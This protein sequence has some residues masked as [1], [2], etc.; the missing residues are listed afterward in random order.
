MK[1]D[2]AA[3]AAYTTTDAATV[4]D[5]VRRFTPL[6][7]KSVWHVFGA[8]RD[9]LEIEDSMQAGMVAPT[10]CARLHNGPD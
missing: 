6:V 10:E 1:H 2:Q 3:F 9:G 7:R 8:G 5:R 4:E